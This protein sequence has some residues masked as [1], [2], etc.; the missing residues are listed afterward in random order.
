MCQIA[1]V[2]GRASA[3]RSNSK[4]CWPQWRRSRSSQWPSLSGWSRVHRECRRS[5]ASKVDTQCSVG[6]ILS[7]YRSPAIKMC[8]FYWYSNF[9]IHCSFGTYMYSCN[10][11]LFMGV[12][13][14][15]DKVWAVNNS[16][17]LSCFYEKKIHNSA[18]SA[19]RGLRLLGRKQ[20]VCLCSASQCHCA[21]LPSVME[22]WIN[23][24]MPRK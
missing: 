17:H 15:K 20:G 21:V 9:D 14:S 7:G 12:I 18:P 5:L 6:S 16:S 23:G 1:S 3:H 22:Q 11:Y 10:N 24:Q 2:Q 8:I 19:G 13:N 4:K